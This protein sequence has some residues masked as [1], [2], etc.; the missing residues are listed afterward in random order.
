MLKTKRF[1]SIALALT[2]L[3]NVFAIG[4]S[5]VLNDG[6]EL[7][8]NLALQV[9]WLS[10]DGTTFTPLTIGETLKTNDV[11]TVRICPQT[12]F[13]V[14][15]SYYVTMFDKLDFSV[16]GANKGAFTPNA[17]NTYFNQTA[18][19]YAGSTN[20]PDAN[21]PATFGATENYT[22]Y[23]AIKA[24]TTADSNSP[25]G[26]LP[27]LLPGTWLFQFKLKV[28]KDIPVGSNARIWMDSRW[29]RSPANTTA[30]GYFAKCLSGQASSAGQS[31]IYNFSVD[32]T[33]ADITLPLALP[34]AKSTISFNSDGGSAVSSITGNVGSTVTPPANPT[35]EGYT[36]AGWDPALPATFPND[37][38]TVKALWNIKQ[39]TI[40]FNSADGT[41]VAPITGNSGSP[42]TAPADPTR[43]NYTFAGWNPSIPA[44]FPQ[45]DLTVNAT[46][47][48]NQSTITFN[49]NGGSAVASVKGGI[50]TAVP[51]VTDP[52][53]DDYTFAGWLP[54]IPAT[55]PATGFTAVAQWT[56]NQTTIT[57]N[58]ADGTSVAP[59][60]GNI[61]SA[62]TAPA[63]P[64]KAGYTFAGWSP[65]VPASFPETNI[66]VTAQ[67]TPIQYNAIFMVDGVVYETVPTAYSA[68]IV[69]PANPS[70]AGFTF[71]GWSPAVGTMGVGDETFNAVFV[72][73]SQPSVTI[74]LNGSDI[75]DS[76]QVLVPWYKLYST[77][78]LQLGYDTTVQNPVRVEYTSSNKNV[79]VDQNGKITNTGF[80]SRTSDITVNIYDAGN[81]IIATDKV[82]VKFYKFSIDSFIA[83]IKQF[84]SI[85]G[86]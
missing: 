22:V 7:S 24:G 34:V 65:I 85:L 3:V 10:S 42:V 2:L 37:N 81:N 78:T 30:D 44:T 12:D 17:D 38:T 57:F 55:F 63:D 5:A 8:A 69:P 1:L 26:G 49:S 59:I 9:G 82:N 51:A 76:Y 60:T 18:S 40:T 56:I 50:G 72:A 21:W 64:T 84:L 80:L 73:S 33:N 67:W 39:T 48:L 28:L 45:N 23:K 58:S 13:L 36:F 6:N 4:A 74:T 43:E 71:T 14:G 52:T 70:K 47:T 19:G 61:G 25:N 68:A 77:A 54:L 11:I 29:V 41:S 35:K 79:I 75:G 66:T 83:L 46:W 86:I 15:A 16:V 27:S 20:I 32:T 53:R 62:V 31:T